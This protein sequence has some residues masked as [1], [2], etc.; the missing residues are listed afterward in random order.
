ML[1]VNFV[2]SKLSRRMGKKITSIP[3]QV[4]EVLANASWP[5]NMRELQNFL[6]RAVISTQGER[7]ICPDCRTGECM[8]RLN[9]SRADW[10]KGADKITATVGGQSQPF[11]GTNHD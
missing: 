4:M 7:V 11:L 1:L 2:V 3:R 6:E 10:S 8:R 9:I 5:A